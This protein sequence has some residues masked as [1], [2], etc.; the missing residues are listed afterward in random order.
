MTVRI[1][2]TLERTPET[3]LTSFFSENAPFLTAIGSTLLASESNL[4]RFRGFLHSNPNSTN[5]TESN[6]FMWELCANKRFI[7]LQRRKQTFTKF[8]QA[9]HNNF[10]CVT[11]FQGVL[12]K[13]RYPRCSW[14]GL[15]KSACLSPCFPIASECSL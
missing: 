9:L 2:M 10:S 4:L 13:K 7:W 15:H 14:N 1:R 6:S 5:E 8:L 3:V 12:Y 11:P